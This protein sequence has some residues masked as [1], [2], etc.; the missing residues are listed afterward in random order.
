VEFVASTVSRIEPPA[1]FG[2]LK[3]TYTYNIIS[4]TYIYKHADDA[5]NKMDLNW[6]RFGADAIR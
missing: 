6:I 3:R 2:P 1:S 4:L 5:L